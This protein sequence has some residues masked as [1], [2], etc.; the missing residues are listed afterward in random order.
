MST[1]NTDYDWH[2]YYRRRGRRGYIGLVD[3]NG[4]D[5]ASA[6][7]IDIYYD[8]IP[9]EITDDDTTIPIPPEFV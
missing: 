2:W 8:E 5:P 1:T 4:D 9:D 3:E 6:Y 7:D